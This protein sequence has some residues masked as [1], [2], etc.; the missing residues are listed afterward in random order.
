MT[1][2]LRILNDKYGEI[3]WIV[4]DHLPD[5]DEAD[6]IGFAMLSDFEDVEHSWYKALYGNDLNGLKDAF[7]RMVRF[8]HEAS[9]YVTFTDDEMKRIKDAAYYFEVAYA[10]VN[11]VQGLF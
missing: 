9:K 2:K 11:S 7:A 5:Q 4:N 6:D 3:A 1:D 10:A 8:S